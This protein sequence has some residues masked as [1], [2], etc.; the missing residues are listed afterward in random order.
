MGDSSVPCPPPVTGFA[1]W[2]VERNQCNATSWHNEPRFPCTPCTAGAKGEI[3]SENKDEVMQWVMG[4]STQCAL[5]RNLM[6]ASSSSPGQFPSSERLIRRVSVG[7]FWGLSS[8]EP[9][10][11]I[12]QNVFRVSTFRSQYIV[13]FWRFWRGV[14]I[15]AKISPKYLQS[16]DTM[17][18]ARSHRMF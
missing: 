14:F 15:L 18:T 11:P 8:T 13:S 6:A 16:Y 12:P 17:N 3:Q 10:S 4:V 7:F 1:N 5:L 2:V 9:Q